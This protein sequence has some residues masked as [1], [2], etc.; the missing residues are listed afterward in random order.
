LID[1]INQ[2]QFP[3]VVISWISNQHKIGFNF[4]QEKKNNSLKSELKR[5]L[6][7]T[8]VITSFPLGRAKL[9][10]EFSIQDI[11]IFKFGQMLECI[12]FIKYNGK[13]PQ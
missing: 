1:D 10:V 9:N 13:T 3:A 12:S 11:P 5:G 2:F 6:S 4:V 8:R 7:S